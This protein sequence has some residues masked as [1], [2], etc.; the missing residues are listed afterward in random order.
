MDFHCG[1]VWAYLYGNKVAILGA[2]SVAYLV[3]VKTMPPPHL[4]WKDPLVKKTW[5]YNFTHVLSHQ[6]A[7][8][9]KTETPE[10]P[11]V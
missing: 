1:Q 4:S 10:S 7:Y 9:Y 5:F 2:F 3:F 11:K 8:P 6:E